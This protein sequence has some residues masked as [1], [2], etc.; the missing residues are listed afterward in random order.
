VAAGV[1]ILLLLGL[2]LAQELQPGRI[3]ALGADKLANLSSLLVEGS[4]SR[5]PAGLVL[6][7]RFSD[8]WR[9]LAPK[10][11]REQAARLRTAL[12]RDGIRSAL[13]FEG[14]SVALQLER[15]RIVMMQ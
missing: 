6:V 1:A 11:R 4:V 14:Q 8:R 7:G 12:G 3:E 10:A 15:G 2:L 5:Q 13:I 9:A